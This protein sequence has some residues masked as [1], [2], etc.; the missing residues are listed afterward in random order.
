MERY[1]SS[2]VAL[3]TVRSHY[4]IFLNHICPQTQARPYERTMQMRIEKCGSVPVVTRMY[5]P[6]SLSVRRDGL[7]FGGKCDL[8][9]LH[10][11]NARLG[12]QIVTIGISP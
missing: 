1:Q 4:A 5:V 9:K 10:N 8:R 7:G 6:P 11:E 12:E 2:L 3:L